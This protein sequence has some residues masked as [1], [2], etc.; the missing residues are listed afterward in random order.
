MPVA[1]QRVTVT[2]GLPGVDVRLDLR[3][4]VVEHF[5]PAVPNC[6]KRRS[7]VDAF[8]RIRIMLEIAPFDVLVEVGECG[9]AI[10]PVEMRRSSGA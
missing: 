5:L 2:T 4:E 3:R 7:A 9:V 6:Q 1:R 10:A 8:R